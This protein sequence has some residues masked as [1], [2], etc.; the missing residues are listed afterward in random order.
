MNENPNFDEA[1]RGR[2]GCLHNLMTLN[3]DRGD[4]NWRFTPSASSHIKGDSSHDSSAGAETGFNPLP[5]ILTQNML[6]LIPWSEE[7]KKISL[8]EFIWAE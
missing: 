4:N 6:K 3:L 2:F 7:K 5:S 1:E 8:S